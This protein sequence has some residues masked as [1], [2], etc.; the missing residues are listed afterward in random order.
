MP[1]ID[2]SEARRR[3]LSSG[4]ADLERQG[5]VIDGPG[6]QEPFCVLDAANSVIEPVAVWIRHLAVCDHSPRTIRSYSYAALT[7]FRVLHRLQV[8]W[9]KATEADTAALV[10]WFRLAAN[11]QRT[12]PAGQAAV[13]V[14]TGK[15]QL[16]LGYG[17]ATI[18]LTLA[19]VHGFYTFHAH[20]GRGPVT[21]PVP[22]SAA[23]RRALSHRSPLDVPLRHRRSGYRQRAGQRTPRSIPDPL[24]AELFARMT[25]DRD[26][27]LLACYV[28]SGARAEELLNLHLEDIDWAGQRMSISSKGPR[29]RRVVPLSPEALTWLSAYLHRH[30]ARSGGPVWRSQHDATQQL[31]YSAARRVLQRA[32]ERLGTNWSLHDLRHTAATRMASSGVLTLPEVQVILGHADLRTT[33]VY[34]APRVDDVI[35][36]LHA[37]FQQPSPPPPRFA[38]EYATD[39]LST[40]FGIDAAAHPLS[41]ETPGVDVTVRGDHA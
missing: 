12:R 24:W 21:N 20:W 23:R 13:N 2:T 6:P 30:P 14:K 9:Q 38:P 25:C 31:S 32:N 3:D 36:K 18:N 19:A 40:V 29:G 33:S 27:A 15:P 34:L 22:E 7:W 37:Y 4:T 26:R 28:S 8:P 35:D 16:P 1:N 10:S 17:S 11:P 39:D 5:R 41:S